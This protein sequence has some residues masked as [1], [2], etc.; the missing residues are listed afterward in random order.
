MTDDQKVYTMFLIR[1]WERPELADVAERVEK[2]LSNR[3]FRY[4]G[5][6]LEMF[7]ERFGA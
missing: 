5:A 7:N 3:A 4:Y 6:L 1:T 2:N